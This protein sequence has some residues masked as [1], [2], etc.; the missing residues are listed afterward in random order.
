MEYLEKYSRIS[1][2]VKCDISTSYVSAFD[3]LGGHLNPWIS[4]YF[5]TNCAAFLNGN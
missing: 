3:E 4:D 1:I 2:F 5:A